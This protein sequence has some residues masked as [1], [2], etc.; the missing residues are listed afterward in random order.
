MENYQQCKGQST[1]KHEKIQWIKRNSPQNASIGNEGHLIPSPAVRP[2]MDAGLP[3][4]MVIV[5]HRQQNF[6]SLRMETSMSEQID[7]VTKELLALNYLYRTDF[8]TIQAIEN[9]IIPNRIAIAFSSFLCSIR[10][11]KSGPICP[12]MITAGM[13]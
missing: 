13:V 4:G 3:H 11:C 1:Q 9:P 10:P 6:C 12:P 8:I 5:L 2:S 7:P